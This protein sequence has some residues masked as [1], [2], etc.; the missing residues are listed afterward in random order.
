MQGTF[1][2][3]FTNLS[4]YSRYHGSHNFSLSLC[5]SLPDGGSA[6]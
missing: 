3:V 5:L 2:G 6:E 4:V 1:R